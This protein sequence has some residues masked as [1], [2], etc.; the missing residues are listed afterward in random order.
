MI[1]AADAAR[2]RTEMI[3]GTTGTEIAIRTRRIVIATKVR[4]RR[5]VIAIG[6]RIMKTGTAIAIKKE[7][8]IRLLLKVL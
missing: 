6:A 8:A 4:T 2:N 3:I 5:I 7:I 1:E